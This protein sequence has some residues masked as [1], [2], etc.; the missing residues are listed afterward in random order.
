M[1]IIEEVLRNVTVPAGSEPDRIIMGWEERRRTRQRVRSL[2]GREFAIALATGTVLNDGDILYVGQDF[3]VAV[4]AE[5][6]DVLVL[7]F[8]DASLAALA[9]YEL[10]NRHLPVSIG[11]DRLTT[12]YDRLVEALLASV[13]ITCHRRKERFE[14]AR[15]SHH[16]G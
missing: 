12:P 15:M 11:H 9:A 4:E 1:I 16:H 8:G 7:P 6:E 14:P 2:K 3:H 10:G 5:E 13:G